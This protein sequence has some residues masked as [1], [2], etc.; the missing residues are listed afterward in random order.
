[1]IFPN[2]LRDRFSEIAAAEREQLSCLGLDELGYMELNRRGAELLFQVLTERRSDQRSRS[3]ATSRSPVGP[4]PS[5]ARG[6]RRPSWTASPSPA[7]IIETGT[8]SY[9]L[10]HAAAPC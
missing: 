10:A 8:T 1:M 7:R 6:S 5:P 2:D 9:R 3:L 4:R